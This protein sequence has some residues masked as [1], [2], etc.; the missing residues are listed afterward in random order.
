MPL[1]ET[2]LI[3]IEHHP[4]PKRLEA[5]GVANWSIWTKEVSE[6]P[7]TYDESET[8][9]L[10]AGEAIVE[11]ENGEPVQFAAGDLVAFPA[12]LSCTWKILRDVRKRYRFGVNT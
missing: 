9:Y 5:L 8:C 12:G 2:N 10:L 7:W 11:P 6:F 1:S 3:Q 4:S